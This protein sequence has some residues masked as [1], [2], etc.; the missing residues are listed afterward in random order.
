MSCLCVRIN[1]IMVLGAIN[2]CVVASLWLDRTQIVI[3]DVIASFLLSKVDETNLKSWL[4]HNEADEALKF[5]ILVT[6][7]ITFHHFLAACKLV[8]NLWTPQVFGMGIKPKG[9]PVNA[10]AVFAQPLL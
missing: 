3:P 5:F 10:V 6:V 8:F 2:C 1:D 4:L 7:T 9:M